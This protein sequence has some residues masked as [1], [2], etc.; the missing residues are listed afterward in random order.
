MQYI[1]AVIAVLFLSISAGATDLSWYIDG[2]GNA[3]YIDPT[4]PPELTFRSKSVEPFVAGGA[5][6]QLRFNDFFRLR[7]GLFYEHRACEIQGQGHYVVLGFPIDVNGSYTFT[8]DYIQLPLHLVGAMPMLFP[9]S[10]YLSAGP[11]I[12]VPLV[13]KMRTTLDSVGT[14][15]VAY[16][17]TSDIR[18][19]TNPYDFGLSGELGYEIPFGKYFSAALYAGYYWGLLDI[20]KLVSAS[21][22]QSDFGI[23]TRA[24][25]FGLRLDAN[26]FTMRK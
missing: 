22:G 13:S 25:R 18:A 5:G 16:D 9:G 2:G 21:T 4:L 10:V 15:G 8:Y 24:V 11:E 14:G 26:L 3:S 23:Y 17:S 7:S 12:G 6:L 19:N 20:Y 1:N